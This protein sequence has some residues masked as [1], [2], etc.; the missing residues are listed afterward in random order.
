MWDGEPIWDQSKRR[1]EGENSGMDDAPSRGGTRVGGI[2][3]TE[4]PQ[5]KP[6]DTGLRNKG[7]K[8]KNKGGT[9]QEQHGSSRGSQEYSQEPQ[10]REEPMYDLHDVVE[11]NRKITLRLC[12]QMR[13][14]HRLTAY[15]L[16][17]APEAQELRIHMDTS[18]QDYLAKAPGRG[19]GKGQHQDGKLPVYLFDC[20][21]D[22]IEAKLTGVR[23]GHQGYTGKLAVTRWLDS[24]F[25]D[26]SRS[27]IHSFGAKGN[28]GR[29]PTGVWVWGLTFDYLT[30]EGRKSHEDLATILDCGY[31]ENKDFRIQRDNAP[32]DG[33]E[34][35]LSNMRLS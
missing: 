28:R 30:P 23:E 2:P 3:G 34:R 35:A 16:L 29:I 17:I 9:K 6:R 13:D 21:K 24:C 31:L 15:V 10:V 20:F 11:T 12:S 33:M 4:A 14:I 1:R 7:G 26:K 5:R 19:Q 32:T 25:P 27:T 22:W 8:G 18:R